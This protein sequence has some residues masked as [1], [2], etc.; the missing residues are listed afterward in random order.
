MD[1]LDPPITGVTCGACVAS[2]T[3]I[4]QCISGVTNVDVH[5]FT[6]HVQV[7]LP[8]AAAA[9]HPA[10]AEW[11]A[12]LTAAAYPGA[13]IGRGSPALALASTMPDCCGG[14]SQAEVVRPTGGCCC[15]H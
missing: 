10:I 1:N 12:E 3:P 9:L 15:G 13:Q 7:Q 14:Q 5:P 2:F 4:L 8:N 6:G 11:I